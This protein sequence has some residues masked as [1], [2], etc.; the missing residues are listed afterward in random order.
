[1]IWKWVANMVEVTG[2]VCRAHHRPWQRNTMVRT[3][4]PTKSNQA[5]VS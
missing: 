2:R 3:A 4:H 1:M 5:S